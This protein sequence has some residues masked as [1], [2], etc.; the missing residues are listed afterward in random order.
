MNMQG[1]LLQLGLMGAMFGMDSYNPEPRR[2][3]NPTVRLTPLTRK[4]KKV[5]AANKMARKSR[6]ANRRLQH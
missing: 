5:R 4:Q 1:R 6:R 3:R 2:K